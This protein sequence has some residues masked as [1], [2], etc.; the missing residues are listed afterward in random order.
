MTSRIVGTEGS[1]DSERSEETSGSAGSKC[2]K[3]SAGTKRSEVPAGSAGCCCSSSSDIAGVTSSYFFRLVFPSALCMFASIPFAP[4][5]MLTPVRNFF[6][7]ST[8]LL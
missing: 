4:F 5:A 3:G 8:S 6:L 7:M 1:A 2:S